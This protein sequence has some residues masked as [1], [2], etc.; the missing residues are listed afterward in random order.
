MKRTTALAA[1]AAA[2]ITAAAP[3]T[4]AASQPAAEISE[5]ATARTVNLAPRFTA[6]ETLT[7]R[8]RLDSE[9]AIN[10]LGQSNTDL[11]ASMDATFTIETI[12]PDT[13]DVSTPPDAAATLRFT[14]L[15][16]DIQNNAVA[17]GSFDSATPEADDDPSNILATVGRELLRSPITLLYNADGTINATRGLDDIA[18]NNA[19]ATII[20]QALFGEPALVS[21]LQP[22]SHIKPAQNSEDIPTDRQGNPAITAS[23]GQSWTL[24]TEAVSSLGLP[25]TKLE[26]TLE[27]DGNPRD[28]LHT[29]NIDG[30]PDAE[31]PEGTRSMPVRVTERKVT[32]DAVWST[33]AH[34]LH[35]LETEAKQVIV[36]EGS[37]SLTITIDS[38]TNLK[39]VEH[40]PAD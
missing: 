7:Y 27:E 23:P 11:A 26:L 28:D 37:V 15:K 20:F 18:F 19:R 5:N 2:A 25:T 21:M 33:K 39:L 22:I 38:K 40:Q 16:L 14:K 13:L 29:V 32:G 12:D 6:G 34:R 35:A 17:S 24:E 31:L 4:P 3:T 30:Q 36:T 1:A 9:K 8:L 10:I